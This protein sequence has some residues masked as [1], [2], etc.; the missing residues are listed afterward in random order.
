MTAM[1]PAVT[2][3]HRVAPSE[4]VLMQ[5]VGGEAV[6]LDLGGERYF[7]L[8]KVGTR[9]WELLG[10]QSD[11]AQVH[12]RLCEEFEAEPERVEQDLLRLVGELAEAGLVKVG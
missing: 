3:A 9:I 5:E 7:G 10:T 6:L 2:L 11:L 1:P 8:N 12:A 4:N